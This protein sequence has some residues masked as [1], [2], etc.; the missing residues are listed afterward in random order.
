MS[1]RTIVNDALSGIKDLSELNVRTFK[2]DLK[3]VVKDKGEG[4]D[5]MDAIA[6]ARKAGTVE[7]MAQTDVK[8]DGDID[9]YFSTSLTKSLEDTHKAAVESGTKT[10]MAIVNLLAELID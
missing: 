4:K 5:W 6:A 8:L 3:A 1:L 7:L 2:G 10:R 9:Q